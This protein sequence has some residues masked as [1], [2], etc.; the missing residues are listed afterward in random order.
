[1]ILKFITAKTSNRGISFLRNKEH[2][3]PR[4]GRVLN[5]GF[6]LGFIQAG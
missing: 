5:G 2:F 1:L 3:S 4:A 6:I